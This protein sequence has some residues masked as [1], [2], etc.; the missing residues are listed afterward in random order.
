MSRATLLL[1][2]ALLAACSATAAT[3]AANDGDDDDDDSSARETEAPP[4][5]TAGDSGIT[6]PTTSIVDDVVIR[7]RQIYS[8]FDGEHT[9]AAPFAVAKAGDD[10]EVTLSDPS[11]GTITPMKLTNPVSA[12]GVVDRNQY[13]FVTSKK[14]GAFS[15]RAKSNGQTVETRYVVTAYSLAD[16]SAGSARY[17]SAGTTGDPPCTSCHA[18]EH[19]V[20]HSPAA[21]ASASDTDVESVLVSGVDISGF[22]IRAGGEKGHRWDVDAP[23]RHALVALLRSLT[24]RGFEPR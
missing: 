9:Y 13:F 8:G 23:Q 18:G 17:T 2:A 20:D 15:I 3:N 11:A 16:W 10:L 19:A 14:A 21:L 12:D 7:P 24:P 22:P 5:P 1:A 4:K 6:V